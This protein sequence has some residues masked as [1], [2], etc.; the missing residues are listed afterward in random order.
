MKSGSIYV[1]AYAAWKMIAALKSII[2][3]QIHLYMRRNSPPYSMKYR[4]DIHISHIVITY[5]IGI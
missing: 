5:H 4:T 2:Q 3:N 1:I